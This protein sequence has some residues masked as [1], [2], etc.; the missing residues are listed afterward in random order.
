MLR[1]ELTLPSLIVSAAA[2]EELPFLRELVALFALAVAL[3]YLSHRLRLVPIVG[4]L[5]AGVLAG[6]YALGLVADREFISRTAEIGVILLLF[7]I[8]VEFSLDKLARIRRFIVLGG[9]LQVGLTTALVAVLLL[10]AGVN[11]RAAIFSGALVALSSTAIV[12][13]LLS[14]RGVTD[15]PAG[16][17]SLGVLIFQD[18]MLVPLVLFLPILGAG[19]GSAVEIGVTLLESVLILALVLVAARRAVPW[20]LD[21][22]AD[23]RSPELFLLTVVV[24]CFGI[25]W[26]ANLGGVSLALGA[27][28]AGLVVSGSRFREHAVGEIIPLRTIFNALFFV[29]IG[30]LLD[31]RFVFEH[32]LPLLGVAAGLLLLKAAIAGSSVLLLRY[33]AAVAVS[34][35]LLLAQIGEFSLV[36]HQVGRSLGLAPAGLGDAGDQ[37][38]LAVAVLLMMTTPFAVQLEPRLRS[39]V[40]ARQPS[41]ADAEPAGP[42]AG[43]AEHVIIGGF[44]LT[45]RYLHSTL[46]TFG[47]A[48]VIVDLNP[49][50]V[51]EAEASGL[52]IVYGDL[53]HTHVL[54]RAG[55]ERA[56]LLVA[57]INDP[58]ALV[59]IVHRARLANP[60]LEIALRTPYVVDVDSL[61]EAGANVVVTEELES[62]LQLIEHALLACDVPSEEVGRQVARLRAESELAD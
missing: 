52:P 35:A 48:H 12:V 42:A 61:I 21:R 23:V 18:L 36:L 54:R 33:P 28:L 7:T 60:A 17:I 43:L 44:G 20:L 49:V 59:R 3:T 27:F 50:S 9:S 37:A 10:V 2:S 13:K 24:I 11:W 16:Q 38:F 45:G 40:S 4:F 51:M 53:S 15:T 25:A 46:S 29:S 30:M 8:G 58:Q 14:D 62:A 6:P 47:V 19:S 34:V 1:S 22:V 26:L 39:L 5:F 57:A 31:M 55:V 41:R 32:W 56:R